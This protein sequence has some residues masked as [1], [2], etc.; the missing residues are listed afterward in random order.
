MSPKF[1]CQ[2]SPFQMWTQLFVLCRGLGDVRY[3]S[4]S[5]ESRGVKESEDAVISHSELVS[6]DSAPSSDGGMPFFS[7]LMLYGF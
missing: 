3:S 2:A 7:V 5:S 4:S 1:S 6:P